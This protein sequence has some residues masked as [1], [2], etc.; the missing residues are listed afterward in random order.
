[1]LFFVHPV[2]KALFVSQNFNYFQTEYGSNHFFPWG[3]DGFMNTCTEKVA[4]ELML[5]RLSHESV[6]FLSSAVIFP[7]ILYTLL[8]HIITIVLDIVH[9]LKCILYAR[10]ATVATTSY[11][12]SSTQIMLG[13][14]PPLNT[15]KYPGFSAQVTYLTN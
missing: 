15:C 7:L 5:K 14:I 3:E 4:C 2:T 12:I 6:H 11:H 9:C 1:M 10:Q 8:I 13:L